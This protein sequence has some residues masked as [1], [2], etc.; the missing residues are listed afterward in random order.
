MKHLDLCNCNLGSL[1]SEA[2]VSLLSNSVS[3]VSLAF[4]TNIHVENVF[5][6]LASLPVVTANLSILS[7]KGLRMSKHSLGALLGFLEYSGSV[8]ELSLASTN[9]SEKKAFSMLVDFIYSESC[10]LK[11]SFVLYLFCLDLF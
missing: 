9:L 2:L 5:S 11:V 7:V 6:K 1:H 3:Q 10:V 8:K 4:N